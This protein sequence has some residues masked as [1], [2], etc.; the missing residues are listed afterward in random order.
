MVPELLTVRTLQGL[1]WA[2]SVE[3]WGPR[4]CLTPKSCLFSLCHL[5]KLAP[6]SS[7]RFAAAAPDK[8]ISALILLISVSPDCGGHVVLP[9]PFSDGSRKV[10]GFQ[11]VQLFF[12]L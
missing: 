9:P 8:L 4:Q 1:L 11:F 6:K 5:S 10:I 7:F 2:K 3:L 12:S